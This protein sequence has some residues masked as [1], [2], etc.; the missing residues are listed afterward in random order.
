M[1]YFT[2]QNLRNR[3]RL[4]GLEELD[5]RFQDYLQDRDPWLMPTTLSVD[6]DYVEKYRVTVYSLL[7]QYGIKADFSVR[8]NGRILEVSCKRL[9][10]PQTLEQGPS[11]LGPEHLPPIGDEGFTTLFTN[12]GGVDKEI[13]K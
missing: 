6:P 10:R 12:P 3:V 5:Q 8:V 11:R 7:N 1:S 13:E 9:V 2:G 4:L